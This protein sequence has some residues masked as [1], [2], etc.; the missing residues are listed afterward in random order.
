MNKVHTAKENV[1]RARNSTQIHV[2][3]RPFSG[4]KKK[5]RW[6]HMKMLLSATTFTTFAVTVSVFSKC[7]FVC[8]FVCVLCSA[9]NE[10]L[11]VPIDAQQSR[12]SKLLKNI[13]YNIAR[14]L[15]NQQHCHLCGGCFLSRS[16]RLCSIVY[17]HTAH[18][19]SSCELIVYMKFMHI[20]HSML[21]KHGVF[22]HFNRE[23]DSLMESA[24]A[25]MRFV[26]I[27]IDDLYLLLLHRIGLLHAQAHRFQTQIDIFNVKLA[28]IYA[29]VLMTRLIM[30]DRTKNSLKETLDGQCTTWICSKGEKGTNRKIFII[31]TISHFN[32]ASHFMLSLLQLFF[33]FLKFNWQRRNQNYWRN[34][35]EFLFLSFRKCVQR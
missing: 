15:F 13:N 23:K 14:A 26:S 16:G 12:V 6:I 8:L 30:L 25:W 7:C 1:A 27:S 34:E 24:K 11:A 2:Y 18:T 28:N 3:R 29:S 22:T 19:H 33:L 35:K 4:V 10:E 31:S 5:L 32:F 9:W 21:I 17:A 20:Q